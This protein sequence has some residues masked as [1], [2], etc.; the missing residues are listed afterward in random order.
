[1]TIAHFMFFFSLTCMHLLQRIIQVNFV[2]QLFLKHILFL[3]WM[4]VLYYY[5]YQNPKHIFF[6]LHFVFFRVW[7]ERDSSLRMLPSMNSNLLDHLKSRGVSTVPALRNLFH[8]EL[9]KFCHQ[10]A[11]S[12]LFKVLIFTHMAEQF[13]FQMVLVNLFF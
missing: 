4:I 1:V 13:I 10:F 11:P 8:E 2:V 5:Q 9:H 7:F 12:E 3:Y 6:E